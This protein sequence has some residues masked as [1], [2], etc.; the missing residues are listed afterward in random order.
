MEHIDE[1]SGWERLNWQAVYGSDWQEQARNLA[2]YFGKQLVCMLATQQLR[3]PDELIEFL[4]G[5][6]R[7][8]SVRF[9]LW[10]NP[11]AVE[12]HE[13]MRSDGFETGLSDFV[14]LLE[15]RAYQA[16]GVFSGIDYGYHSGYSRFIAQWRADADVTSWFDYQKIDLPRVS[17][18]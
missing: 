4:N 9:M 14:G 7:C 6:E 17:N 16:R 10:N 13:E 18:E 1:I 5:P 11:R 12:V 15:A 3:V 2:R 8:P